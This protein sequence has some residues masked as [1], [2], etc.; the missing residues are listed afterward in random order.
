M[1]STLGNSDVYSCKECNFSTQS[2]DELKKHVQNLYRQQSRVFYSADRK[3]NAAHEKKFPT[4][5]RST[6]DDFLFCNSCDFKTKIIGDLKNHK[7]NHMKQSKKPRQPT[8]DNDRNKGNTFACEQCDEVLCHKDEFK[9]HMEF[10]HPQL[11]NENS[12]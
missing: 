1:H 7:D 6:S 8:K 4:G 2:E 9:L 10:F 12:Q 3:R 11:N 5:A